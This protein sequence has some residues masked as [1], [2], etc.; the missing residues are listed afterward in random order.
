MKKLLLFFSL[1]LLWQEA[2]AAVNQKLTV[3]ASAKNTLANKTKNNKAQKL[4]NKK[5]GN[6][7]ANSKPIKALPL[8]VIQLKDKN[9]KRMV[10]HVQGTMHAIAF[11]EKK[12]RKRF[13]LK[14]V[15]NI[16][17]TSSTKKV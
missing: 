11:P 1:T 12:H 17:S 15:A 6:K 14:N 2:C 8:K 7:V 16:K 4:K 9:K 3:A 5:V 10:G 13:Y